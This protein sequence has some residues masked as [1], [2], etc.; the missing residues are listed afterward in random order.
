MTLRGYATALLFGLIAVAAVAGPSNAAPV[1]AGSY[2]E[3]GLENECHGLFCVLEF[4]AVP[5][6]KALTI[7]NVSCLVVLETAD[8]FALR[9]GR[10]VSSSSTVARPQIIAAAPVSTGSGLSFF[11]FTGPVRFLIAGGAKPGISLVSFEGVIPMQV[12]CTIVGALA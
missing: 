4:A 11:S 10:F 5:P 6:G 2:Y 1:I 12:D 9:L 8:L 3:E 7:T